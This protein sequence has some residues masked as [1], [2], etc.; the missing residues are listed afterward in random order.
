MQ[1]KLT[2]CFSNEGYDSAIED[3]DGKYHPKSRTPF[4]Y[5]AYSRFFG[6]TQEVKYV[7]KQP[8]PIYWRGDKAEL[9]DKELVNKHR[10][11]YEAELQKWNQIHPDHAAVLVVDSGIR[12]ILPCLRGKPLTLVLYQ[13]PSR[14]SEATDRL[15][16][17]KIVLAVLKEVKRVH[18]LG[19]YH[20]DFKCDNVLIDVGDDGVPRAYLIDCDGL[21]A[22]HTLDG[23]CPPEWLILE[24]LLDN[25]G[26]KSDDDKM[27]LNYIHLKVIPVTDQVKV[28]SKELDSIRQDLTRDGPTLLKVKNMVSGEHGYFVYGCLENGQW[29][30]TALDR[31]IIDSAQITSFY[32]KLATAAAQG[33]VA[34]IEKQKGHASL[35]LDL[36][37]RRL[38]SVLTDLEMSLSFKQLTSG[39]S[40]SV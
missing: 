35:K 18:E 39:L 12:L 7:V 30:F 15:S 38:Q 23:T 32:G 31:E 17:G 8:K 9:N 19:F 34:H 11:H 37:I 24:H 28:T 2:Y 21:F 26:V 4:G 6:S 36:A 25:L 5:T 29:G 40:V 10:V 20:G 27:C 1:G 22:R 16:Y 14:L 33:I 13:F 3:E